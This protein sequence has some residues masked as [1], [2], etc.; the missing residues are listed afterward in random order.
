M[1]IICKG[2]HY[3]DNYNFIKKY[4]PLDNSVHVFAGKK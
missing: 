4:I 2:R 1:G 3:K